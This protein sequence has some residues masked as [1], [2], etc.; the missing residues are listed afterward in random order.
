VRIRDFSVLALPVLIIFAAAS[1]AA[2]PAVIRAARTDSVKT[3]G[4]E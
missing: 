2:L 1:L 4:T 3:P